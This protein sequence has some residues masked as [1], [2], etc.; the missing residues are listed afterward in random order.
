[1]NMNIFQAVY[2]LIYL[3]DA[4]L[5]LILVRKYG[6][7]YERNPI[8]RY[9]MSKLGAASVYIFPIFVGGLFISFSG[10]WYF[11]AFFT[12]LHAFYVLEHAMSLLL[13]KSSRGRNFV[14][15]EIERAEDLFTLT[16]FILMISLVS[17][18]VLTFFVLIGS[19][20]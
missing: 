16:G 8:A 6:L 5:T 14:V 15:E 17:A 12:L 9:V 20:S 18:G 2:L 1:M 3:V 19:S 4:T 13:S 10:R 11:Y 7:P